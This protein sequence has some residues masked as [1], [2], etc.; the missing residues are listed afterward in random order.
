MELNL[1]KDI[2]NC[3]GFL[4]RLPVQSSITSYDDLAKKMWL[5]PIVGFIIG[6][7]SSSMALLL[8]KFL[9]SLLAGFIILGL[10]MFLTGGHHTDD[11]QSPG[12]P[13][14]CPRH[15]APSSRRPDR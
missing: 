7:I 5:F 11:Q 13:G 14:R 10:L 9:P 4:T 8:F 3:I 12:R 6:I 15:C 2:K 1:L